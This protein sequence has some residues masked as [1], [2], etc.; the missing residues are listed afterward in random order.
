MLVQII[1]PR[2]GNEFFFR[3]AR[4]F[5]TEA[6]RRRGYFLPRINSTIWHAL[7]L[8][9]FRLTRFRFESSGDGGSRSFLSPPSLF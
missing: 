9:T 3:A 2:R 4:F 5:G 1:D 6:T 8:A 7:L